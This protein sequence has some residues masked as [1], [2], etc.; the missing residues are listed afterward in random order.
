M[1][2]DMEPLSANPVLPLMAIALADDAFQDYG[3]F[4]EIEAIPPPD[5][6]HTFKQSEVLYTL[7]KFRLQSQLWCVG[8]GNANLT[9][10]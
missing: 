8:A 7:S 9:S 10:Q 2:E 1:Y 3:S 6:Q 5:Q 4:E